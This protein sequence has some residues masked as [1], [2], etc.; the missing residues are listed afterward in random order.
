MSRTYYP[1]IDSYQFTAGMTLVDSLDSVLMLYAYAGPTQDSSISKFALTFKDDKPSI[2]QE[3][4]PSNEL[5][6]VLSVDPNTPLVTSD[7]Q[8]ID[9]PLDQQEP[10]Q[11]KPTAQINLSDDERGSPVNRKQRVLANKANTISSLSITLTL[12]SIL[13]A[14]R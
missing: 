6:P 10:S 9:Q 8:P 2:E 14:L 12:L 11:P 3:V 5:L 1:L 7:G 13:V 4:E